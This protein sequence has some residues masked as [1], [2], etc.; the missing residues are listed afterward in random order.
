MNTQ[1]REF[2]R[3]EGG[4][5][6]LCR[7]RSGHVTV[8]HEAGAHVSEMEVSDILRPRKP[9]LPERAALL[10]LMGELVESPPT[11]Q[12]IFRSCAPRRRREQDAADSG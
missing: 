4:R 12:L 6:F 1:R 9:G 10:H 3:N 5:W 8:L 7:S 2:Y 11:F